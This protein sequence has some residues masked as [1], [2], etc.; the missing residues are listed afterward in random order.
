MADLFDRLEKCSVYVQE[1][2]REFV[3][4]GLFPPRKLFVS[5]VEGNETIAE[6]KFKGE[7]CFGG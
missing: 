1:F 7:D 6:R 4:L 2:F 3:N 5:G